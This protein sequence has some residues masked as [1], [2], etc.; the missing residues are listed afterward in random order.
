MPRTTPQTRPVYIVDGNRTP[1]LKAKGIGPFSASDLA[2]EAARTLLARMPFSP[3]DIEEVVAGCM[4]PS[5]DEANIGRI[6]ALR[7]GCGNHVP[8]WTVQRNCASGMQALDSAYKDI[9]IG[10][11][12]LVLAGGTEAMSRSPLIYNRN[13]IEWFLR[14]MSAKSM[15][16]RVGTFLKLP[17]G[18]M[19][20]PIIALLH[21]LTD[22][23]CGMGMGQTAEQVAYRFGISREAM[24]H[25]AFESHQ[26][27][28]HAFDRGYMTEITPIIDGKGKV[29]DIDT[30]LRPDTTLEKLATLRPM[31]DKKYGLV[32][33]GNSSQVTDGAC[34]MVLAS[35]DA[36]EKYKLPVMAEIKDVQWGACDPREMGLG[37]VHATTPIL[38][39]HQYQLS[40]I[41]YW[42]I[43][44]AFAGQ[45]LGCL[46]AWEDE[47]YCKKVLGLPGAL[48]AIDPER[49]DV[50]GGSVAIG[51]PVGASGAR[52]TLH[53]INVLQRKNAK[54]GIATICIGGG[55]GGAMLIERV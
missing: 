54:R 42:E 3:S 47:A 20:K 22:P 43:N 46:A 27:L 21:G 44:E 7:L 52:I 24:D 2:V 31:F 1:F 34:F 49:L 38:Q 13:V 45:V 41:D 16:A 51:H 33:A 23:L 11:H 55:Q 15:G 29:Y 18:N 39:R 14:L 17:L 36:V 6:I 19:L 53:L 40:D 28:A 32:T 10:R 5:E 8:G 30:G 26:R 50:D 35:E 25:F 9:A 37:P 48:G 4:I 12:D